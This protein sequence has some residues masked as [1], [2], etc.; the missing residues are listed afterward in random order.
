MRGKKE[1]SGR[2]EFPRA[3]NSTINFKQ[4][5]SSSYRE[6]TFLSLFCP[7]P[8]PSFLLFLVLFKDADAHLH[9][10]LFR[11]AAHLRAAFPLLLC[12]SLSLIPSLSLL[13]VFY[14][15]LS[16][17]RRRHAYSGDALLKER[18][19]ALFNARVYAAR[20]REDVRCISE[21]AQIQHAGAGITYNSHSAKRASCYRAISF[22]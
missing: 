16:E 14:T 19:S 1:V 18:G 3:V 7:H 6:E 10:R 21:S 4:R 13:Y 15:P 2:G 17:G 11:I 20:E 12:A 5:R 9:L 22:A 8:S